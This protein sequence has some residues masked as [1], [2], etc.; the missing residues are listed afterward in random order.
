MKVKDMMR[1]RADQ[2]QGKLAGTDT[3]LSVACDGY[4]T[5]YFAKKKAEKEM[6]EAVDVIVEIL[7]ARK[8]KSVAHA[9]VVICLQEGKVQKDKILVRGI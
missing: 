3:D 5:P 9:G 1:A 4:L 8:M 6:A 2:K 7:K